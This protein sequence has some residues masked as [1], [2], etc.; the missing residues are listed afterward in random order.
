MVTAIARIARRARF[1]WAG[2]TPPDANRKLDLPQIE[3]IAIGGNPKDG[4]FSY[5]VSGIEWVKF[6][7]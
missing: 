7:K 6:A 4:D 1:Q 5:S 2:Y 3:A